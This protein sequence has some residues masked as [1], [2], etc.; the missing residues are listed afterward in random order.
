[1]IYLLLFTYI[2][3]LYQ[4]RKYIYQRFLLERY[5]YNFHFDK[6]KIIN[7]YH[8]MYKNKNHLIYKKGEL[9]REKDILKQIFT[10]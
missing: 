2:I 9:L 4:K 8:H 10:K 5:L 7:N 3:K 1:M 6:I